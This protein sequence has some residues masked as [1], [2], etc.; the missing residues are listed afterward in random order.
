MSK[1][2][3]TGEVLVRSST[4]VTGGSSEDMRLHSGS[5]NSETG[6]L[7]LYLANA[8]GEIAD[9]PVTVD[10]SEIQ[11]AGGA[12]GFTVSNDGTVLLTNSVP[13]DL[14][15]EDAQIVASDD[16]DG[17]IS[18]TL[19]AYGTGPV[20]KSRRQIINKTGD[21][22]FALTEE[23]TAIHVN[24]TTDSTLTI[25]LNTSV[26]F[27]IG[28]EIEII[29]LGTGAVTIA[30]A[31]GVVLNGENGAN[32]LIPQQYAGALV[33]KIATNTWII[34]GALGDA[35]DP[36]DVPVYLWSDVFADHTGTAPYGDNDPGLDWTGYGVSE[37]Q[38]MDDA[39]MWF[40]ENVLPTEAQ[41]ESVF[42]LN[43]PTGTAWIAGRLQP[44]PRTVAKNITVDMTGNDV[45]RGYDS[46]SGRWGQW[47]IWGLK[48]TDSALD[49]AATVDVD[50]SA[51]DDTLIVRD[52]ENGHAFLAAAV[53]GAIV[54]IRT[55]TTSVNYHPDG[56]RATLFVE[57]VNVANRSVTFT[58]PLGLSVP[59]DNPV[60][61]WET[62][63]PSTLTLL[64]GSLLS[65]DAIAGSNVINMASALGLQAGDWLLVQTQEALAL[66]D[67]QWSDGQEPNF[68]PDLP[69]HGVSMA[70]SSGS[71]ININAEMHQIQAVNG[72]TV[73]LTQALA[74]N[75]QMVWGA[76]AYKIDPIEGFTLTGGNMIGGRSGGP[77]A[78]DHQYVWARYLV[79]STVKD[80]T[81]DGRDKAALDETAL[82]LGFRRTGQAIRFDAGDGNVAENCWVGRPQRIGAGE[83]YGM[84]CRLGARNTI[85]RNNYMEQCRHSI[86]FWGSSGGCVAEDNHTHN[87]SSSCIDTHGAWNSG[88]IIRNNLISRDVGG[89]A[90]GDLGDGSP[91][92]IRIGN[93]RFVFD[94]NIQVLNN[95]VINFDGNGLSIVPGVHNVVVDGLECL[96]VQRGLNFA[97]NARHGTAFTTQVVIRNVSID[98]WSDRAI[99]FNESS[100]NI[101]QGMIM[102]DFEI[103]LVKGPAD[104]PME[105]GNGIR[106]I[107]ISGVE[108]LIIRRWDCQ[109]PL[110]VNGSGWGDIVLWNLPNLQISDFVADGCNRGLALENGGGVTNFSID[111]TLTNIVDGVLLNEIPSG[112]DGSLTLRHNQPIGSGA[113]EV[114]VDDVNSSVVKT[115]VLI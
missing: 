14:N 86:E 16:G 95:R 29:R 52:N 99:Y 109:G 42:D 8:A 74:K 18:V 90:S 85:I 26:D 84:S 28:T 88:I 9:P 102:E 30:A 108:D 6:I 105:P 76:S 48:A 113:G 37:E 89:P 4:V 73:T 104:T 82:P 12:G 111:M 44:P 46:D 68:D 57:S 25:P 103:G 96:N 67:N 31:S 83:G 64:Q 53:A 93:N 43:S 7:T 65:T 91:D 21:S 1:R 13:T 97:Q 23:G 112:N 33:R 100:K 63:D 24:A 107:W 78:W 34:I 87:A 38:P 101:F 17:T 19:Q 47:F 94:E 27:P 79:N 77:S 55:N 50:A 72:N 49:G 11:S 66:G 75:K 58:T 69:D 92:A 32:R 70:T 62:S 20:V 106:G 5:F 2:Q 41:N 51:N 61:S 80:V 22:I 10:M 40:M 98:G 59:R 60:G 36:F 81:F 71:I 3:F 115:L 39:L 56:S 15:F 54:E 35:E 114:S 45:L 110:D